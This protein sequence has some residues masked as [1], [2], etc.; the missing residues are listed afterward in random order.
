MD[1]KKK[2]RWLVAAVLVAAGW[3]LPSLATSPSPAPQKRE[4]DIVAHK[5]A[6][7]PSI[8]QVN[9][10][11]EVHIRFSS[12]DVM[13]GFYL[14]GYDIDAVAEP[15]KTD[16]QFRHPSQTVLFT[17]AKEIVFKADRRG[18][19]RYRCSFTCGYMHPFMLGVLLV[20]PNFLFGQAMG[21]MI[22]IF[23]AGFVLAWPS[24]PLPAK[25]EGV[26]V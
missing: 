9:Q 17:Q 20:Q 18:K 25:A 14:E 2:G 5:Y 11:D 8:I 16:I 1:P 19:F 4:F 6:Y 22:G 23:L 12:K 13:H 21:L 24:K 15:G 26:V 3:F 7:E 10:G